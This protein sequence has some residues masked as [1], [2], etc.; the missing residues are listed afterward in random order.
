LFSCI[1]FSGGIH[2]PLFP[3][4]NSEKVRIL[5]DAIVKSKANWYK[6][7][8][9]IGKDLPSILNGVNSAMDDKRLEKEVISG[10]ERQEMLYGLQRFFSRMAYLQIRQQQSP[11]IPLGQLLAIIEVLPNQCWQEFPKWLHGSIRSFP[12]KV[13]EILG[14]TAANIISEHGTIVDYFKMLGY[15]VLQRLQGTNPG[16]FFDDWKK[17]KILTGLIDGF[18]SQS[19]SFHIRPNYI[20]RIYGK[21][22][23]DLLQMYVNIFSKPIKEHRK[24]LTQPEYNVGPEG[25]RLST[26]DRFP[27]IEG[28]TPNTWYVPNVRGLRRTAPDV[29]HFTLNEKCR[30]EYQNVK[31]PL[32]ELYLTKLLETRTSSLTIIP[33]EKWMTSKGEVAGPDLVVI[34]RC[35]NPLVLGI[36]VKSRKMCPSTRFELL[37]G[38]LVNN[39]TDIWNDIKK[40]PDKLKKVFELKGGYQKHQKELLTAHNFPRFYLGIAGEAP[41]MFGELSFYLSKKDETFPLYGFA[42]PWAVMSIDTFEN[43]IEVVIQNQRLIAELMREYV[44]DCSNMEPSCPMSESFRSVKIDETKSYAASF[45]KGMRGFGV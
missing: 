43:F 20:E 4:L 3:L 26:L 39:Y 28:C 23:A 1:E 25:L 40:L 18:G 10:G 14:T 15:L 12:N 5:S 27:L 38:D 7:K 34:D 44:E 31:G 13:A 29:I 2:S 36:E 17:A 21:N 45:L 9:I 35:H 6:D 16:E 30:E 19:D 22:E 8:K 37:D 33:E 42:E 11:I 32:L 24:L 41:Y